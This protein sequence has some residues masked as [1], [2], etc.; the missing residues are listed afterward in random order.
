MKQ[1][2]E[3][4]KNAKIKHLEIIQNRERENIVHKTLLKIKINIKKYHRYD[5]INTISM[6]LI[7]TLDKV[8]LWYLTENQI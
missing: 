8:Y 7:S 4:K 3:E 6:V 2:K 5:L 1:A